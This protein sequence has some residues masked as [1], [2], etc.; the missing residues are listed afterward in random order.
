MNDSSTNILHILNN[1][2]ESTKKSHKI[3]ILTKNK[4][5]E[6]LI[7]CINLA[8]HPYINFYIRKVPEH[9]P[10]GGQS[11][12]WA[13]ERLEHLSSRKVTGNAAVL[14]LKETLEQL[15][16]DDAVVIKR[17]ILKDLRCGMAEGIVNAVIP[18]LIPSYPCM[19]AQPYDESTSKRIT[20]PAI[21]QLKADGARVNFKVSSGEVSIV[22]RSGKPI[23]LHNVLDKEF[24]TISGFYNTPMVFDGELIV[25][26]VNGKVV[27]RKTGNGIINKA[28]RGTIS[29]KEAESI[30]VQLWDAIPVE[31]FN[32]RF[33]NVPYNKR[34]AK[35]TSVLQTT[36]LQPGSKCHMIPSRIVSDSTDLLNHFNEMIQQ[37]LEGVM[38]KNANS[39]WEDTRSFDILK[40]KSVKTCDLLVTGFNPGEGKFENQ[41]GSLIC[42][43]SDNKVIVSI[44][45]FSDDV[46]KQITANIHNLIGC[47]IVEILYNERISSK[48]ANTPDSLFL[49]RFGSFRE[50]KK[51]PDS[52]NEIK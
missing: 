46:R 15:S 17:I 5:N 36:S 50:D 16:N 32:K 35:L 30:H 14:F 38:V 19:L 9:T 25:K 22:G 12:S 18:G 11:I 27:D 20:Y 23:D 3:N 29:K 10:L 24:I 42:S 31:D 8:L 48:T 4:D 51:I 47:A 7:K 2:G 33:Y 39:I 28:I 37:G 40:L 45:G 13:L 52:S 6:I 41:V 44:S 43:S 34:W 49:P 21:S 1:I 26:T